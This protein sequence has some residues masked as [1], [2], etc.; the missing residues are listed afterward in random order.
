MDFPLGK[1]TKTNIFSKSRSYCLCRDFIG[2]LNLWTLKLKCKAP[3]QTCAVDSAFGS[4]RCLRICGS[5][6]S[7]KVT[8]KKSGQHPLNTSG[9]EGRK[10]L[11][12][13]LDA[14]VFHETLEPRSLF[15]PSLSLPQPSKNFHFRNINSICQSH[16][17]WAK[18]TLLTIQKMVSASNPFYI[19]CRTH[20]RCT[21]W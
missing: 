10:Q 3:L 16:W 9:V 13:S 4:S 21:L 7:N 14:T 11:I 15:P 6:C 17:E 12:A 1:K 2:K 8:K 19:L 5:E 18:K 20:D